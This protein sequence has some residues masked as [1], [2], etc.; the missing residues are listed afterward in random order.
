[1]QRSKT[2]TYEMSVGWSCLPG[3]PIGTR[4]PF[5]GRDAHDDRASHEHVAEASRSKEGPLDLEFGPFAMSVLRHLHR[6]STNE[7]EFWIP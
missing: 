2:V 1:M 3:L 4:S 5:Q 7:I 6:R